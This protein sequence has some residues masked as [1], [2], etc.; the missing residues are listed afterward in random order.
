MKIVKTVRVVFAVGLIAESL[1][2]SGGYV[3]ADAADTYRIS[4]DSSHAPDAA[5]EEA[6]QK[7]EIFT[8]DTADDL[9]R[10][11]IE[12][13]LT[14]NGVFF[15]NINTSLDLR[16]IMRDTDMGFVRCQ[17]KVQQPVDKAGNKIDAEHVLHMF[18][19][20]YRDDIRVLQAH[21]N[22]DLADKLTVNEAAMLEKA[23]SIIA[24]IIKPG[25]SEYDKVLA[26]HDY[27]VLNGRYTARSND[28]FIQASLHK[29]EGIL[30]YGAGVCSSYAGT[31]YLLLGMADIEALFVPG[32][33]QNRNGLTELHAW[34]KVKIDGMWYN[35]DVTWNDPTPDR[36]GVVSYAYFGLTDKALSATHTWHKESYPAANS[37]YYNYY[38]YNDLFSRDYKQFKT[39]I[40]REIKKQKYNREITVRLYVENYDPKTYDLAFIFDSL[41]GVEKAGYS[42]LSGSSGEFTLSVTRKSGAGPAVPH[43]AASSSWARADI[44]AAFDKGFIPSEMQN[45]YQMAITRGEFCRL[46]INWVEYATGKSIGTFL[47][48]KGLTRDPNA[49]TDTADPDI[50]AAYALGIVNGTTPPTAESP[51]I[52]SPH[53][54]LSREEAAE[55][56]VN[57]CKAVGLGDISDPIG[58]LPG[59][60]K[61]IDPLAAFTRQQ[62][63]AIFNN[64]KGDK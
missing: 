27:I 29:T 50:L 26:I 8:I 5:G 37:T 55:M 7:E 46:A 60:G 22:S 42:R 10:A 48:G 23:R 25:M 12:Q 4:E 56:F 1:V 64:A 58:I 51:G 28:P 49:F 34:N 36:S 2:V 41:T 57:T 9:R 30:L 13:S 54:Q 31:M 45:T 44:K 14:L 52:F 39:I 3:Y 62:S 11:F 21:R 33:A 47:K 53:G 43:I 24:A 20:E 63:I 19:V 15:L 6:G 59:S 61:A 32:I 38:R 17:W 18:A 35:I 16:K 40:T